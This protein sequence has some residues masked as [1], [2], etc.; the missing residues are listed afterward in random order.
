MKECQLFLF[1]HLISPFVNLFVLLPLEIPGQNRGM[2]EY[3]DFGWW[4]ARADGSAVVL[5]NRTKWWPW[6]SA[7]STM[8]E[9]L[10][11]FGILMGLE[12]RDL[13]GLNREWK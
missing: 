10:E 1:V 9:I 3:T 11:S 13:D 7:N 5:G 12:N 4:Q 2:L 8:Q 6:L